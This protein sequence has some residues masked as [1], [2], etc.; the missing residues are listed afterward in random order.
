MNSTSRAGAAS[1]A[2]GP[3]TS[4]LVVLAAV[5]GAAPLT[6][7]GPQRPWL[8]LA[9]LLGLAVIVAAVLRTDVAVLLLVGVGPLEGAF[10]SVRAQLS[11]TKVAGLLCFASFALAAARGRR[12]RVDRSHVILFLLFALAMVSTLL[13]ESINDAVVVTA[14]YA[15]FVALYLVITQFAGD[16]QLLTR[17]A[18][19]ISIATAVAAV[20]ALRVFLFTSN[21]FRATLPGADANDL[22]FAFVTALPLT[23]W[24]LRTPW[25]TK[26]VPA[27]M[28]GI[29]STAAML[30]FSRGAL[31]GAGVG[32]VWAGA[33]ERRRAAAVVPAALLT[34]GVLLMV[35][36]S[37]PDRLDRAFAAK[38]NIAQQNVDDRLQAWRI[39]A[40]M[41]ATRPLVGLGP[42]NF[43]PRYHEFNDSPVGTVEPTVVHNAYLDVAAELGVTGVFLFVAFLGVSFSRAGRARRDGR[44]PP[45]LASAVRT[46]IL[47]GMVSAITLSEQYFAPFWV[48]G[49]MATLVWMDKPGQEGNPG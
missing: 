2:D 22:G 19:V 29:I 44:G 46:A 37:D 40:D 30:T 27:V 16:H 49:G 43:G 12:I 18:W 1:V 25:P 10:V 5:L 35:V 24:L 45:G 11:P 41:A 7:L 20:I 33:T 38:E 6:F 21:D 42:G 9:T 4:A 28:I 17:V 31:L 34:I 47:I 26:A 8:A 14:R 36:R 48:L 23:F 13:A 15:S 39:A 32:L 3:R